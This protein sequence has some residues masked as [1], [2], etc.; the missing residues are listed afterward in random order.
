MLP[1]IGLVRRR[2]SKLVN[3]IQF[4]QN[5]PSGA[6]ILIFSFLPFSPGAAKRAT[7]VQ[8]A[9]RAMVAMLVSGVL[10]RE[11]RRRRRG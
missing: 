7:P 9:E 8:A 11:R 4:R 6:P 2:K 5:S 1:S 10:G 3:A